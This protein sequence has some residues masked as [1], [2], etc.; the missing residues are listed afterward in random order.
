MASSTLFR[1]SL[2]PL[3][4]RHSLPSLFTNL[5]IQTLTHKSN[6]RSLR[7]SHA[8]NSLPSPDVGLRS[9]ISFVIELI[10]SSPPT[11]NSSILSNMLIFLAGSPILVSGLS[12][13]GIAA[14]FLLGTLTWRAFGPSGFLLVAI[15]FVI[16]RL[17]Q[18]SVMISS[19]SH[20]RFSYV[21]KNSNSVN[22]GLK[23][24]IILI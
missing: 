16:V 14:A 20:F 22:S 10:Q 1:S 9:T 12:V 18:I 3:F 7:M 17:N 15:Y 6:P 8:A 13:S 11:W 24:I 2:P 5:S 19:P 23:M 4:P 21:I